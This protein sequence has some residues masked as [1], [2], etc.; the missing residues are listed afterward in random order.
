MIVDIKCRPTL[1]IINLYRSF[2]P[3]AGMSPRQLFSDQLKLIESNIKS[4]TVILGDFN[5]DA[6]M[7]FRDDY[8]RKLLYQDLNLTIDR[9]DLFQIVNFYTW[10]RIINNVPKESILDHIYV[11]NNIKH[12]DCNNYRPVYG[13]HLLVLVDI[14]T[15]KNVHNDTLS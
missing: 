1:R 14:Y 7:Q 5:I 4:N 2:N 10:G 12:S 3:Q 9:L 15:K 13:D 8:S 11:T 6:S